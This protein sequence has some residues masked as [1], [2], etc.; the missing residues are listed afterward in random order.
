MRGKWTEQQ[1]EKR[2]N[3][4]IAF[5]IEDLQISLDEATEMYYDSFRKNGAKGGSKTGESKVRGDRTYYEEIGRAG[6]K[7]KR[8]KK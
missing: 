4:K 7:A 3:N 6:G 5:L 2:R 8:G 1:K